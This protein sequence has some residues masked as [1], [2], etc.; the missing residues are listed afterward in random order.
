MKKKTQCKWYFCCPMRRFYEQGVLDEKWVANYCW[1]GNKDCVRY[2]KE[3]RGEYHPDYM[4]PDG[5]EDPALRD[6]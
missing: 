1:I 4:L 3:E 6:R 5:S 2:Q